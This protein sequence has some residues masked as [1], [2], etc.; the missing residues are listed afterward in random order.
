MKAKPKPKPSSVER[1]LK[2]DYRD[3]L[4]ERRDPVTGEAVFPLKFGDGR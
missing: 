2:T 1:M 4:K 3:Y